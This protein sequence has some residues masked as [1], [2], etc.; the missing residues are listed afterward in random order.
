[1]RSDERTLCVAPAY[2]DMSLTYGDCVFLKARFIHA[3]TH[4]HTVHTH[5]RAPF[6]HAVHTTRGP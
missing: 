4:T 2:A 1:M 6:T 3:H 5:A